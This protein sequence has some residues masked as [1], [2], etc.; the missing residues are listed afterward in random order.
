MPY[1]LVIITFIVATIGWFK[2]DKNAPRI[3]WIIVILLFLAAVVQ[4]YIIWSDSVESAELESSLDSVSLKNDSLLSLNKQLLGSNQDLLKRV[5]DYQS[6]LEHIGE[7]SDLVKEYA[8]YATLDQ[9]GCDISVGVGMSY[10]TNISRIIAPALQKIDAQ[11]YPKCD[12]ES[13]SQLLTAIDQF[14]RFPFSY[15]YLASCLRRSGQDEWVEYAQEAVSILEKTT[16]ID[17]H[18]EPHDQAL[19]QMRGFLA[20]R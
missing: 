12:A 5:G 13:R 19:K 3:S 8:Y 20:L 6:E 7:E 14:P 2:T 17:G 4:C 1:F 15:Y 16:A 10:E 11:I 18:K 9:F